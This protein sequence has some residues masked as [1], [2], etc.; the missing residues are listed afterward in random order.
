MAKSTHLSFSLTRT[1]LRDRILIPKYYDPDLREA[2]RLARDG[3]KLVPLR[4]LLL[5]GEQGSRLGDWVPRECYGSGSIPYVRT[6]DISGWRIRAD[7]KKGVSEEIYQQFSSRQDV[8]IGDIL[9]VAHGT[10]LVGAVGVVTSEVSKLVLQDHVF[11]LRVSPS[12]G[13]TPSY[14][15]AALSTR[16]VRRQVRA[17]QFS[18]DIIDKLGN[19][20]LEISVP[21][22]KDASLLKRTDVEVNR[23]L[24]EQSDIR[25]AIVQAT[26]VSLRM[27]RE[28]ASAHHGFGVPRS[29]IRRRILI[30][31]YY[32][33]DVEAEL[34]EAQRADGEAWPSLRELVERGDISVGTGV[35]V[36]KMAYGT[37]QIP[38][39]RTSDIIDM[40]LRRDIRQ[41]VS[42]DIL[43]ENSPKAAVEAGDVLVVRDGTYLVG[44]SALVS[45]SDTPAL[46]CGGIFRLR[47]MRENVSAVG[48]LLALNLGVVRRQ[49]RA[50]QFTRD[51]IDTLGDRLFEV[52]IPPLTSPRW[53]KL[54][55]DLTV[56]F[57]RKAQIKQRI[58]AI[59]ESIEP[60]APAILLGRPGWS[61]R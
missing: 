32:D 12:S 37:G 27:L 53:Q 25:N 38:F 46:F 61:M 26:N 16:Y 52:R 56:T 11:R 17:R 28:R 8:Q 15:L 29:K 41:G 13:I 4:D 44:H 31:K 9:M 40:E 19:R 18:A 57:Q 30:P 36:G 20:H 42:E 50:R 55:E 58:A 10:Y 1:E 45:E 23:V 7:Y 3:F 48:L 6:S 54:T 22:P 2:D 33:P 21:I 35:E 51:V 39:V 60:R 47:C 5:P 34:A 49:M 24:A 43:K 14:L 59:I